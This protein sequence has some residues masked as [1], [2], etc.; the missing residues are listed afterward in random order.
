[1][2]EAFK[3]TYPKADVPRSI[4]HKMRNTFP[5]IRGKLKS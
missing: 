3:E 1:M 5:K 4:T 2:E